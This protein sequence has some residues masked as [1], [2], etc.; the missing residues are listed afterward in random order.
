MNTKL[1]TGVDFVS[2]RL[3]GRPKS[4]YLNNGSKIQVLVNITFRFWEISSKSMDHIV[5]LILFATNYGTKAKT[6][7]LT[8]F[9]MDERG[10]Q[11]WI[12]FNRRSL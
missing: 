6:E 2:V 10:T 5:Y 3:N 8:K 9:K 4:S 11:T 1:V 7:K 12:I